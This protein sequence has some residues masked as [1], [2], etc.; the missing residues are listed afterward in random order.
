MVSNIRVQ[1][2]SLF[3]IFLQIYFMKYIKDV[4]IPKTNKRLKSPVVLGEYF[5]VIVCHL[6][7]ACYIGHSVRKLFFKLS[8]YTQKRRPHPHQ[9]NHI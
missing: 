1:N 7:M 6:I 9:S 4:V 2:M 8:H 5:C 3:D